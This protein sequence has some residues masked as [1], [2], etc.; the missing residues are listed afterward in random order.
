MMLQHGIT[1]KVA[2]TV[3]K[4][5]RQHKIVQSIKRGLNEV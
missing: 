2:S 4:P 3:R 1:I 5:T